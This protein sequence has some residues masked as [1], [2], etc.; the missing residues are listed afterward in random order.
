MNSMPADASVEIRKGTEAEP[1]VGK[2]LTVTDFVRYQGASG[3]FN[4]LHHDHDK[5]VAAGFDRPFAVGMLAAGV[6]G[7]FAARW[8][9]PH[10]IRRFRVRFA[11]QAWPGDVLTYAGVVTDVREGPAEGRREVDAEFTVTRQTGGVHLRGWAT[12]VFGDTGSTGREG[13]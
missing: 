6:L 4:P 5:A 8:L 10:A 13:R 9:G 3:D 2:P 11:E 7:G 1:Y 12:F